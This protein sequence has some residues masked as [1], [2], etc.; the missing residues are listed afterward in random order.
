MTIRTCPRPAPSSLRPRFPHEVRR[1][2]AALGGS[3]EADAPEVVTERRA[4]AQGF[5]HLVM[6]GVHEHDTIHRAVYR[7]MEELRRPHGVTEHEDE[8]VRHRAGGW[9]AG[10]PRADHRRARLTAPDY[11]RVLHRANRVRVDMPRAEG[12]HRH[13]V[14]RRHRR[15]RRRR[16]TRPG[17]EI[18]EVRRLVETKYL[19]AVA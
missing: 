10:H 13:P 4:D 9:Q 7:R 5:L 6:K 11:R 16:P 19:I 18:A 2:P 1:H 12:D 15:P 17:G 14:R 3:V 8:R